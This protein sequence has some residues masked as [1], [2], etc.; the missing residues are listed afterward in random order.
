VPQEARQGA[1]TRDP[2]IGTP[3]PERSPVRDPRR[4]SVDPDSTLRLAGSAGGGR[5][6]RGLGRVERAGGSKL[7]TRYAVPS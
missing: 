4:P 2:S 7:P 1:L 6:R 5:S 3:D